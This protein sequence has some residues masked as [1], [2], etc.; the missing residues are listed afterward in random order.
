MREI[1]GSESARLVL[2]GEEHFLGRSASRSPPADAALEGP[3]LPFLK[4][5]GMLPQQVVKK[6]L[7]LKLR[8]SFQL[9]VD[10]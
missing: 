9:L 3:G 6:R 5:P 10:F 2:L 7:R 1:R 4:P 8:I